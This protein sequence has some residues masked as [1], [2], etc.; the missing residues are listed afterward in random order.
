[1]A[2]IKCPKMFCG[3]TDCI[4]VT[5]RKKY[6]AGKGIVG[7]AVGGAILGPVGLIA[8]AATGINGKR[9][10]KSVCQKC[11]KVFTVKM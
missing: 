8:G 10:V 6:K 4:P 3:S 11:G 2:R 1:M 5:E 9:E 7:G